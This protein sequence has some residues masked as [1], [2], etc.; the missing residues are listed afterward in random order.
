MTHCIFTVCLLQLLIRFHCGFSNFKTKLDADALFGTFTHHKNLYDINARVTSATYYSQLSKRSHFQLVSWVAK[1]CTNMSR[2]VA[3]ASHPV[4]NRYSSNP[5][6]IWT[7]LASATFNIVTIVSF[8][9]QNG[10]TSATMRLC[11]STGSGRHLLS[12]KRSYL[13]AFK[14]EKGVPSFKPI[15]FVCNEH[16]QCF[17]P[18]LF[19]RSG[20][21]RSQLFMVSGDWHQFYR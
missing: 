4:N 5:D 10:G 15:S 11:N 6:T 16:T 19:H 14:Q 13:C 21:L 9:R 20:R 8:A 1:T 12:P 3:N 18:I 7:N 17:N 2:L